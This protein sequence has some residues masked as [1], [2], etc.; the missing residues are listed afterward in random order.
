MRYVVLGG[1]IAG[2]CCA[3][4]LCRLCSEHDV[5]LVSGD[6]TLKVS[7]YF[8]GSWSRRLY[9]SITCSRQVSSDLDCAH[10]QGVGNVVRYTDSLESFESKTTWASAVWP[11]SASTHRLIARGRQLSVSSCFSCRKRS[12]LVALCKPDS[13][14]RHSSRCF[15]S[16]K[17]SAS[18]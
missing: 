7:F 17:A 5:A 14:A 3:E 18:C 13:A 1:G 10:L 8:K 6:R 16:C 9:L 4:E 2:V 15:N 11:A 12:E